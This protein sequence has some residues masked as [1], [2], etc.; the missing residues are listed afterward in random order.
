MLEKIEKHKSILLSKIKLRNT[1]LKNRGKSQFLSSN[2]IC[3]QRRFDQLE[4][5]I[6]MAI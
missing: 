2:M 1:M 4:A 6:G 5:F 3:N